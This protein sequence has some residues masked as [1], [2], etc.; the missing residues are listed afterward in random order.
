MTGKKDTPAVSVIVP[1]YNRARLLGRALQSILNQ[2][3]R[4][5]EVIVVDDGSTDN[6]GE[7]V[8]SFSALDIRYIRHKNNKGEA[9]ARNTGVLAARGD[10]IAFLDSDDEWLPEKL[11]KQMAV[12]QDQSPHVGIVYS[13]MCE[14]ERTGKKRLWKSPTF[15]PEDGYFHRRAL[16]YQVYG[17]G[18]G[19]SIVRRACF[20]KVGLF[21]ERLS[22]YVDFDFFIRLSREFYF[23]HIKEPL[24]NYYVTNDSFRWVT[25]AHIGSREVILEKY[26]DDIKRNRKTLSLH[27]WKMGRFLC[28]HNETRRARP[29]LI[30]ATKAYPFNFKV[31]TFL[32]ISVLPFGQRIFCAINSFK[33]RQSILRKSKECQ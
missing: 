5:F 2:T 24:M 30:K 33:K 21:D 13:N 8:R 22:Y 29:Y 10:F 25:S 15:M 1:T 7:V 20:E 27:Y 11:E 14:I 6:T 17:I 12:F 9:A 19:S 31:L 3:Y 32:V 16:N 4:D 26:L 18:I 23:Y 28:I